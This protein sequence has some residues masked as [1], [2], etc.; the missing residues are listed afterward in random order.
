MA[1]QPEVNDERLRLKDMKY[2]FPREYVIR[3]PMHDAIDDIV[4]FLISK[5]SSM[6]D[7]ILDRDLAKFIC[8]EAKKRVGE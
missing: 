3:T 1:K 4:T 5:N 2:I 6:A 8:D 7:K